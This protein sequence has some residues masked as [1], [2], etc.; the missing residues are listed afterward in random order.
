[1]K[2]IIKCFILILIFTTLIPVSPTTISYAVGKNQ[3][4]V[5]KETNKKDIKQNTNSKGNT[6]PQKNSNNKPAQKGTVSSQKTS[7]KSTSSTQAS[8]VE[9]EKATT[10]S[11]NSN[12]SEN[13]DI[14]EKEITPADWKISVD[15]N[16]DGEFSS[17]KNSDSSKNFFNDGHSLLI[18]G[19]VLVSLSAIGIITFTILIIKRKKIKNR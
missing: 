4:V 16:K 11:S 15:D 17:I 7:N 3:K 12:S 18:L 6:T 14:P 5:T 9:K 1:M 8:N 13:F 19:I 10:S 2:K